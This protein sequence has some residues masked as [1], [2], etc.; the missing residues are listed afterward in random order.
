MYGSWA[1]KIVACRMVIVQCLVCKLWS[2]R[3]QCHPEFTATGFA[4]A[5]CD[6]ERPKPLHCQHSF[7]MD[8]WLIEGVYEVQ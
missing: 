5:L 8:N 6:L 2:Q 1:A 7:G 3:T 4:A